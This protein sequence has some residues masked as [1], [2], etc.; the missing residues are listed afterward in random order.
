MGVTMEMKVGKERS[1]DIKG[2]KDS[3][4]VLGSMAHNHR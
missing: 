2:M 4:K 3:L 1:E